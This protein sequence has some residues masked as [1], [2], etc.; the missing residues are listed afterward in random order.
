VMVDANG[1]LRGYQDSADPEVLQ[2]LMIDLGDLL[3]E[4]KT[5]NSK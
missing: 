4:S 3:R 2:K 1:W 5:N